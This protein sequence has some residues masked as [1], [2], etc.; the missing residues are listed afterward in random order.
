MPK[1]ASSPKDTIQALVAKEQELYADAGVGRIPTIQF[2]RHKKVPWRGR[3][4]LWLLKGCAARLD[5]QY[6]FTKK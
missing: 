1:K 3:F 5:Y 6:Y 2:P 4:A